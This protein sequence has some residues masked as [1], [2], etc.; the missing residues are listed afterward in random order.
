MKSNPRTSK[1]LLK[2]TVASLT[3]LGAG[4]LSGTAHADRPPSQP[5]KWEK[6]F[7]IAKKGRNDCTSL[8]GRH[9]CG[10]KAPRD[11][12]P[13]EYVW[14][15][16]GT[17]EKIVNGNPVEEVAARLAKKPRCSSVKKK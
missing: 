8:D 13:N 6:C 17:C 5:K 9:G 1:Q 7:G 15:P 14:V 10:G 16:K 3:L 4:A 12:D 11:N 2:A